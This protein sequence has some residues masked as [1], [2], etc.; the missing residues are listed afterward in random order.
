MFCVRNE[1]L[2]IPDLLPASV[3]PK[4]RDIAEQEGGWMDGGGKRGRE[5]GEGEEE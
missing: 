4:R 5:T 3:A 1:V 2:T